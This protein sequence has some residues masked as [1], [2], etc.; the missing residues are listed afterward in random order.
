MYFLNS[1]LLED[2]HS[3]RFAAM[4]MEPS[5]EKTCFAICKQQI[6]AVWS[7]SLYL[8]LSTHASSCSCG[9]WVVSHVVGNFEDRF[10]HYKAH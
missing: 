7:G 4:V 9:G 5:I 2:E 8:K 6:C 10:S 1:T 3:V